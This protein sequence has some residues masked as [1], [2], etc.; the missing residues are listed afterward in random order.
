LFL[1]S[2]AKNGLSFSGREVLKDKIIGVDEVNKTLLIYDFEN[3]DNVILIN[4]VKVRT[5]TLKNMKE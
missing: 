4:M 3:D 1:H 5:C 2:G